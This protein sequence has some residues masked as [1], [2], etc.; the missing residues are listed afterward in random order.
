MTALIASDMRTSFPRSDVKE[1]DSTGK[2]WDF[3]VDF[4]LV[5]C[6]AGKLGLCQTV[7]SELQD[8]LSRLPETFHC[9][10]IE[11]AINDARTRTWKRVLNFG[12]QMQFGMT[13]KEW[14]A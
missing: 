10:H 13:L 2:Q 7:V 14:H 1:H 4:P 9:E 8:N 5:A 11:N 12:L 3:D 6:V